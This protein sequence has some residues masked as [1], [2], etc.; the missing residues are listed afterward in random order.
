[1]GSMDL[2]NLASMAGVS[3][4]LHP[5]EALRLCEL[6]SG[7]DVLELGAF[8]GLSA[9]CMAITAKS[10]LSLDHFSSATDGQRHTGELTTLEDYK[11]AVARF[12]NVLPPVIA[13]SEQGDAIIS[14]PFDLVFV[15]AT[16]TRKEVLA[17]IDR[18]W[19]KVK[20]GGI[21][22]GHDYGHDHYPGVKE[23]FDERF[24]TAPEGTTVGTLRWVTKPA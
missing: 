21:F 5:D 19:P 11:R 16:H 18:W 14:G 9:F 15:D 23:A 3:G 20:P 4:F 7:K 8:C 6:A 12:A 24:G 1:M 13:T 22:C 2:V 10:V 17:D